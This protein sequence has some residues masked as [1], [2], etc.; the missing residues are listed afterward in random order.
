MQHCRSNNPC[1]WQRALD[2]QGALLTYSQNSLAHTF[3]SSALRKFRHTRAGP[4]PPLCNCWDPNGFAMGPKR[5][6]FAQF[7]RYFLSI[8]GIRDSTGTQTG[9]CGTIPPGFPMGPW[10]PLLNIQCSFIRGWDESR[11][12]PHR[13]PAQKLIVRILQ[14]C[15]VAD[16]DNER[17][18]GLTQVTCHVPLRRGKL[19]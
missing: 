4:P 10:H 15:G 6:T 8:F 3:H 14:G 5:D 13:N 12:A 16:V 11:S 2:G 1:E 19:L 18:D 7:L 17:A 9:H